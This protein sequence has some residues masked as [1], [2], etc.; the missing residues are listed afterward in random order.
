MTMGMDKDIPQ[1]GQIWRGR[2]TGAKYNVIGMVRVK[3][4]ISGDNWLEYILYTDSKGDRFA[5]DYT[6]FQSRFNYVKEDQ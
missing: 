5:R 3:Y 6:N 1:P 2:K 4:G